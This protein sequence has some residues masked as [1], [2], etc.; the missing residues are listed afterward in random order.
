MLSELPLQKKL[1]NAFEF[2]FQDNFDTDIFVE[3]FR[4]HR[5]MALVERKG[6]L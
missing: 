3:T 6:G 1:Q 5:G 2:L 4:S